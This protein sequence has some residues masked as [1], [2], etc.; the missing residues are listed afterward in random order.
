MSTLLEAINEVNRM[1]GEL[2]FIAG[3]EKGEIDALLNQNITIDEL[4]IVTSKYDDGKEN[5]V[6]TVV[7]DPKH[8]YRTGSSTAVAALKKLAEALEQDQL[9]W[10]ALRLRFEQMKSKQGRRYYV[11]KAELTPEAE[12][13]LE[14]REIER[15]ANEVL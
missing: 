8:F 1:T 6:F 2:A 7:G 14:A 3:R 9:G 12:A 13:E 5:A 11:V 10:N 15:V 4:A